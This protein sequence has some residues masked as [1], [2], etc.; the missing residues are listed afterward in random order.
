MIKKLKSLIPETQL[1]ND[2]EINIAES[3]YMLRTDDIWLNKIFIFFNSHFFKSHWDSTSS[4]RH[5]AHK[6]INTYDYIITL[7]KGRKKSIIYLFYENLMVL[8]AFEQ[9]WI[10]FTQE[11]FVPNLV[12]IGPAVLKK[13]I[14]KFYQCIFAISWQWRTTDKFW[15]VKLTWDFGSGELKR[16]LLNI[17]EQYS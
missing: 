8:H 13:K 17:N 12:D 4:H 5:I 1:F 14:L 6:S 2:I 11:C 15:S 10:P 9:T 16:L 7:F 3:W